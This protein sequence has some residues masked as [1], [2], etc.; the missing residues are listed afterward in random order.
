MRIRHQAGSVQDVSGGKKKKWALKYWD[1][2]GKRRT[3]TLEAKTKSAAKDEAAAYLVPVNRERE[4]RAVGSAMTLGAYAE[5]VYIP[6]G[7]LKW[8]ASTAITTPQRVRQHIVAGELSGV[9][10]SKLDRT[11]MQ[12]F[13]SARSLSSR[14]VVSKLRFDLNAICQLAVADGIM[15][16]NQAESLYTPRTCAGPKQPVMTADQVRQALACLDIRERAF[17]RLAIY[18]GMRP[19]EIIALRWSDIE[20]GEALADDRFYKGVRDTTKNDKVR[21]VALSPSVTADLINWRAFALDSEFVF[22]SE[23]RTTPV[24][25]ENLWQRNIRP[26]FAKIGLAWADFRC[27][28]RTNSTLMKAAGA[29]SKVSA[30]NRGHGLRVAME[31]YTHSTKEQKAEAVGKLE[32][33]I[34]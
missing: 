19:G 17:C 4:S 21:G 32:R 30:D 27:M 5:H 18:A 22:A 14:S 6:F 12:A 2:D 34:Q 28:R 31:E 11:K 10:I 24:K 20:N 13:L 15:A 1:A 9:P 33:M 23:A 7:L 29:D 16:R 3:H 26:R 25:Y 8:K